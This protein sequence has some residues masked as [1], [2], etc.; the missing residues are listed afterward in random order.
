VE[1]RI[2]FLAGD[3]ALEVE[4]RRKWVREH[5]EPEAQHKYETI[6][7]KLRL[8]KIILKERWIEP[9]ETWKLQSLG[10]TFGDILLQK[11]NLLWVMVEDEHGR[12]PALIVPGTSIIVYPLTV[13]SKRIERGE[14]VDIQDLYEGLCALV[15]KRKA[16]EEPLQ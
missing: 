4:E 14:S 2:E 16:L 13:I 5:F 9:H 10:I 8:L 7:D 1:Q 3:D 15:D 11:L 12:D 6:E